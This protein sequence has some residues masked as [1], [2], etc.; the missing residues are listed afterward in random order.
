MSTHKATVSSP[1]NIAF[2]KYWGA[3]DLDQIVP[4]NP[5]LSMTLEECTSR[6]TVEFMPEEGPHEVRWRASGQRSLVEAPPAFAERVIAHLDRLKGWAGVS[7]RFRM[8]TENT[9]PAAAGIASSASGFS[10]LTLGVLA[11]LGKD[12]SD[13]TKSRLSR[14]SGSGSASRSVLGGY[15]RWPAAGLDGEAGNFAQQIAPA[16]HWDLRD[17]IA[18]AA[19]QA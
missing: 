8:A 19:T 9:F 11:A 7:G 14:L 5:S 18:L 6:T 15:V 12:E 17:V 16:S 4:E 13:E 10:A 1:S 3:R 2:V